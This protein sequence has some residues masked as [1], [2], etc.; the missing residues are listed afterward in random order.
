MFCKFNY[1]LLSANLKIIATWSL[2]IFKSCAILPMSSFASKRL[3]ISFLISNARGG[4]DCCGVGI[5][6]LSI[7]G[8]V[9]GVCG[10][11]ASYIA[12][13]FGGITVWG[14]ITLAFGISISND[15]GIGCGISAFVRSW[16]FIG[17]DMS[18][19]SKSSTF[20]FAGAGGDG[21]LLASS[22]NE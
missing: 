9:G 7:L 17:A 1:A 19:F 3:T 16:G 21:Y 20:V 2:L 11:G 12:S 13:C 4:L 14:G 22:L 18:I 5:G 6:L 10:F 8:I 15:C